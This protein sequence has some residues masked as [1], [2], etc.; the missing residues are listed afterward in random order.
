MNAVPRNIMTPLLLLSGE[1]RQLRGLSS[2]EIGQ[3]RC[4]ISLN[5]SERMENLGHRDD[6]EFWMSYEFFLQKFR[7]VQC[8]RLLTCEWEATHKWILLNVS[9]VV[10]YHKTKFTFTVE[11]TSLVALVLSQ[12]SWKS[13]PVWLD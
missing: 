6:G 2:S 13:I 8:V 5:T 1:P 12:V 3:F 7:L 9:F 11:K 4:A 10:E